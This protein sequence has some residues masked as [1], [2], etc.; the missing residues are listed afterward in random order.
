M[1]KKKKSTHP[2]LAFIH[3]D[4]IFLLAKLSPEK[5]KKLISGFKKKH[6]DCLSE[7]FLNFLKNNLTQDK[8]IIKSLRKYKSHI[9]KVA[10]KGESATSRKKILKSQKG[11][12]IL[13]TLLP[14]AVSAIASL[15][16][17]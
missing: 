12:A 15:L 4:L 1:S 2:P 8:G 5:R 7:I 11:G 9:R 16:S 6:V 17:R 3:K 10:K 14:L 13:S